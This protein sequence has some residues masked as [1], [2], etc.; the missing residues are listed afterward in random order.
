MSNT[1]AWIKVCKYFLL[2][3]NSSEVE[4]ISDEPGIILSYQNTKWLSKIIWVIRE[5]SGAKL[6][7]LPLIKEGTTVT[8]LN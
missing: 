7:R 3:G 6:M 4:N 2:E 8:A 5:D 1:N